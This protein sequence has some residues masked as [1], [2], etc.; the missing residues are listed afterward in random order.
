MKS[1]AENRREHKERNRRRVPYTTILDHSDDSYDV[2]G[3][4]GEPIIFT[5]PAHRGIIIYIYMYMCVCMKGSPLQLR[6]AATVG[7]F[8][9]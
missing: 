7:N 9:T 8:S 6:A 5:S 3:S 4:Y 2:Q 1:K